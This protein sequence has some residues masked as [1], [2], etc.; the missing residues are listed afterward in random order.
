N[1]SETSKKIGGRPLSDLWDKHIK[2]G[3][4]ISKDHY[5]GTCNYCLYYKYKGSSQEFK[6]HLANNCPNVPNNIRQIYLNKILAK[7]KDSREV[8]LKTIQSKI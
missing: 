5:E 1:I 7:H 4:E 3:K 2:K 8:S 6:E